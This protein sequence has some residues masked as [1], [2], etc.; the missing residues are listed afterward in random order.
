[1]VSY[2]NFLT[3]TAIMLVVLF[4][5]QMSG[6]V[7]EQWNQFGTNQYAQQT[8]TES[9][10]SDKALH[11]GNQQGDY[12]IYVGS[13]QDGG[14]G[15]TVAQWSRYTKRDVIEKHT[16]D[17]VE[18]DTSNPPEVVLLDAAYVQWDSDV[19]QLQGWVAQGIHLIFCNL[20]SVEVIQNSRALQSI[21]GITAVTQSTV[22]LEGI[23]LFQGFLLGGEV[24]YQ[25][26]PNKPETQKQQDLALDVPW[27]SVTTGS[28]LYMVGQLDKIKY[29]AAE[30]EYLPAI[31]WRSSIG[32]TRV[33]AVNGDYLSTDTGIGILDAMMAEMK[34]YEMYP[35]VNAQSLVALN[36]P[37]LAEE[38]AAEMQQRYS[39]SAES[40]MRDIIWPDLM[41]LT[42]K[43]Q[44]KITC[45]MNP[46]LNHTDA[47]LPK[48]DALDYYFKV[49]REQR[50]EMGLSGTQKSSLPLAEKLAADDALFQA[51][52]PTYQFT[53]FYAGNAGTQAA[54]QQLTSSMLQNVQ[55]ILEDYRTDDA[56]FSYVSE[57]VL[58]AKA[59]IDGFSHTFSEDLRVK[60]VQTALAYSTITVDMARVLYPQSAA[61]AWEQLSNRLSRYTTTYWKAFSAFDQ[62]TLSESGSRMRTVLA[63][64]YADE[65]SGN[66]ITLHVKQCREDAWFLL[67]THDEGIAGIEGGTYQ[68]IEKNAYLIQAKQDTVL[69]Q[70]KEDAN[71]YYTQ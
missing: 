25:A 35:V 15:N 24:V 54:E 18:L 17:A 1:M 10:N 63:M 7:K 16:V 14:V 47:N 23:K 31:I 38:N 66:S 50:G 37:V 44:A 67:R 19:V 43:M 68:K 9:T 48:T 60:S 52:L 5:F 28:K 27:Y 53:S 41:T 39:R 40:V 59:T 3:I 42:S 58:A 71:I 69:I 8:A 26:D 45:M 32:S 22:H 20:P 2:K 36:Y 46:Q 65:R 34:D 29:A 33:F 57:D 6:V 30:N 62:T 49:V 61:D 51:W 11:A 64:D 70:V 12:V 56:L 13:T 4:M 21:L 55:T